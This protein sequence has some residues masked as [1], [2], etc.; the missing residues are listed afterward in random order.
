MTAGEPGFGPARPGDGGQPYLA[1]RAGLPRGSYT[2]LRVLTSA[3]QASAGIEETREYHPYGL[4]IFD[5]A[6]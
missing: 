5:L 2:H 4:L 3:A 1:I 6:G